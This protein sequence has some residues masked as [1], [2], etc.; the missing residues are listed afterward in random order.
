MHVFLYISSMLN[1]SLLHVIFGN[2]GQ[3]KEYCNEHKYYTLNQTLK[4]ST[5]KVSPTKTHLGPSP[6]N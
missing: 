5:I 2:E 3:T 4:Q 1:L 6:E